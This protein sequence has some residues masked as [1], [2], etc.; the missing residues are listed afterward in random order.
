MKWII[1]GLLFV[2]CDSV[3]INERVIYLDGTPVQDANVRQW[4]D[5]Y[6]GKTVT[7]KDG[8]WQLQ[9]PPDTV[10]NLCIENPRNDNK[11]VCFNGTLI[12]PSLDGG[13]KMETL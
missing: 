9:V 4:G 10:I 6:K 2:S 12:T 13:D 11:E 7:D 1:F 3:T 8:H 5:H